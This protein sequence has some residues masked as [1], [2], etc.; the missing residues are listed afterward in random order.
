MGEDRSAMSN[1]YP[2]E[3]PAEARYRLAEAEVQR[4]ETIRRAMRRIADD[5][6][7][8]LEAQGADFRVEWEMP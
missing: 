4:V 1:D 3:I 7:A 6:N 2:W 5:M 8:D